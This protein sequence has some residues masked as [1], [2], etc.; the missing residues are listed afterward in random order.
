M[1][2]SSETANSSKSKRA[3]WLSRRVCVRRRQSRPVRQAPPVHQPLV[4]MHIAI[5]LPCCGLRATVAL[6]ACACGVGGRRLCVHPV[7]G[8]AP[9]LILLPTPVEDVTLNAG[10]DPLDAS[11]MPIFG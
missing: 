9:S 10:G 6:G 7:G 4:P 3:K 11:M 8:T 5:T 2:L 1:R